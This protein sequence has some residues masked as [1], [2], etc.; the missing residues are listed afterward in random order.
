MRA[1]LPGRFVAFVDA[2]GSREI[3]VE[4][5]QPVVDQDLHFAPFKKGTWKHYSH[6]D[7]LAEDNVLASYESADGALWFATGGGVSRFDGKEFTTLTKESGLPDNRVQAIAEF[8]DGVMWFGTRSGLCRY[9]WRGDKR[10]TMFAQTNGLAGDI[11]QTLARDPAGALWVGT[12]TGLTRYDGQSF[13]NFYGSRVHDSTPAGND[14]VMIG[15]A[16]VV[17]ALRPSAPQL[18]MKDTVLQLSAT[19]SYALLPADAFAGLTNATVEGWVIWDRPTKDMVFFDFGRYFTNRSETASNSEFN[20]Q[21]IGSGNDL[22]APAFTKSQT[23][24]RIAVTNALVPGVWMHL[25]LVTGSEGMK[26]F[27]NGDLAGTNAFTGSFNLMC[28]ETANFLGRNL[29]PS[30]DLAGAIAEFRVWKTSRTGGANPGE[31]VSLKQLA[32]S[33]AGSGGPVEFPFRQQRRGPGLEPGR[34]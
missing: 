7:G 3:I 26:F 16:T 25:A 8:P 13:T 4:K 34:T 10:F 20:I 28:S 23:A 32:D 18:A 33:G 19:N 12:S 14:G 15:N 27:I 6:L 17:P 21:Q 24:G 5:D 11:I 2:D 22:I 30:D 31:H 29:Y 1:Q 9:D